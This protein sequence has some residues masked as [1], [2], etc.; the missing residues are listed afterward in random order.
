M[1]IKG[2]EGA[3][4]MDSDGEAVDYYSNN[5]ADRLQLRAASAAPIIKTA[6]SV[7]SDAGA[8]SVTR[9][10]V[11]YQGATLILEDLGS[12]YLLMVDLGPSEN[13][14]EAVYRMEPIASKLR[15]EVN[16]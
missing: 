1:S 8:G 10:V 11:A 15:G 3:V 7:A 12:G 14:G 6:G 9:L 2:A 13:I 16:S 5:D 4:F